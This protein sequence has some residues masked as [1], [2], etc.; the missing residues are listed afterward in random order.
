M[1]GLFENNKH[2]MFYSQ[3]LYATDVIFQKLYRL[4]GQSVELISYYSGTHHLCGL[5]NE[6]SVHPIGLAIEHSRTHP[7]A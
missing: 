6:L 1:K 2:F 5:K 3:S 7:R 4:C